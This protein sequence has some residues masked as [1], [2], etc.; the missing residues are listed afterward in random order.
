MR[1]IFYFTE[2]KI[3]LDDIQHIGNALGY[4]CKIAIF[5]N[6]DV[7]YPPMLTIHYSP[8][9]Y[10]RWEKAIIDVFYTEED[11]AKLAAMG[12]YSGFRAQYTWI[13]MPAL[14]KFMGYVLQ[15]Y[16]GWVACNDVE[17]WENP[18]TV[19]NIQSLKCFK[20]EE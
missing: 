18:Y 19:Q 9:D 4:E 13:S 8:H 2:Q 14:R 15:Q 6:Q 10:W 20:D 7:P 12:D 3:T 16:G 17:S 5:S 11:K 1:D